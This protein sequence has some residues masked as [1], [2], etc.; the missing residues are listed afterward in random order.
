MVNDAVAEIY[1]IY[2]QKFQMQDAIRAKEAKFKAKMQAKPETNAR[3]DIIEEGLKEA[4]EAAGSSKALSQYPAVD[5][6]RIV[7]KAVMMIRIGMPVKQMMGWTKTGERDLHDRLGHPPKTCHNMQTIGLNPK[8]TQFGADGNVIL[9]RTGGLSS[10]AE[11]RPF[12][13]TLT[14]VLLGFNMPGAGICSA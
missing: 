7:M 1:D 11:P 9:H 13:K 2:H 14:G 4:V 12:S 8:S 6:K 10:K 3:G 5:P